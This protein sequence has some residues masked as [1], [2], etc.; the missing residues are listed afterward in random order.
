MKKNHF[1][2]VTVI[3]IGA[4]GILFAQ[5]PPAKPSPAKDG[6]VTNE[7]KVPPTF[8]SSYPR[9]RSGGGAADPFSAPKDNAGGGALSARKAPKEI[10]EAAGIVVP[11]GAFAT[12]DPKTGTLTVRNTKEQHELVQAYLDSIVGSSEKQIHVIVEMIEVEHLDFSDWLLSHRFDHNATEFRRTVQEWV[13]EGRGTILETTTIMARSGQRAKTESVDEYI[14]P[15]EYDPPE[16]PKEVT[17]SDQAKAP[18]T[19]VTPT[20]FET[21]NMGRTLEV[22]PVLGA[23]GVTIDLNL[24]PEFVELEGI[25]EWTSAKIDEMFKTTMPTFHTQRI[26]TQ[27]TTHDGEYTFLGTTRPLKAADPKRKDPIVLNFVRADVSSLA[28]WS[29]KEGE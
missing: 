6:M 13:R 5:N 15:T 23:D 26:T 29:V 7:Y 27:I 19:G 3:L 8:I 22:D 1:I 16:I 18:V 24:A 25:N 9:D 21:R 17:L 12:Y 28:R 4:V 10:L 14:Y 20:A 11:E 2:T